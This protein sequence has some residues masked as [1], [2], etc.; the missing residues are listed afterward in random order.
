MPKPWEKEERQMGKC[1]G[2]QIGT[3]MNSY[4][5]QRRKDELERKIMRNNGRDTKKTMKGSKNDGKSGK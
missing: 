4:N 1:A 3:S 5:V 2:D